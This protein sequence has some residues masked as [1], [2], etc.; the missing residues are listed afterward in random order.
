MSATIDTWTGGL[1]LLA[2]FCAV[3]AWLLLA[4]LPAETPAP[5]ASI[6]LGTLATGE[7]GVTP[8]GKPVLASTDLRPGRG[9]ESG[10]VGVRNQTPVPL[11]VSVRTSAVR[12]ELDRS[13]WIQIADG[14]RTLLRT[15]LGRTRSWSPTALRLAPDEARRLEAR[16][17]IPDGASDGW[18]AAKGEVT[19]ELRG[20]PVRG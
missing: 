6:H 14:E 13:A 19:L 12:D 17:W 9:P 7:L 10:T 16:V 4:G 18:Q 3:A 8:L 11:A 20:R 5:S 1:G 15:R 2:G